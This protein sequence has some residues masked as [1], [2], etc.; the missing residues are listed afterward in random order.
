MLTFKKKS[1]T[2]KVRWGQNKRVQPKNRCFSVKL[3][4]GIVTVLQGYI[5]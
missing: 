3:L 5:S 4:A 1:A 2:L